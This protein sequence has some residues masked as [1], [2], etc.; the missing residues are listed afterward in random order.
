MKPTDHLYIQSF[1]HFTAEGIDFTHH[2]VEGTSAKASVS[3]A[4]APKPSP[5]S[6]SSLPDTL[7]KLLYGQPEAVAT[8]VPAVEMF[9][10][11]ISPKGR[12][13]GVFLLL[14]PTGTGKTRTAEALA[15][16]LHGNSKKLLKIDCG[17]YTMEHEIAKLI[18]APPGYLGH[19]DTVPLL[20]QRRLLDISTESCKLSILLFDEIEKA[21]PSFTRLL[22][23]ILDH[24]T[25]HL[26]DNQEVLFDNTLVL[27]T[28]NLGSR[29]MCDALA[30]AYGFGNLTTI[31]HPAPSDLKGRLTSIGLA[32]VSRKFT[33]EFV[34]RL[35]G[36]I[37]Y[38]PLD[39]A[40]LNLILDDQL[41]EVESR[42]LNRPGK[43]TLNYFPGVRA[44]LLKEGTSD[45][46][47]ARELKRLINRKLMQPLA[48]LLASND[49]DAVE[50]NVKLV[51]K[52][53]VV[54]R[55]K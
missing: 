22:L 14:G 26:G 29:A 43:V 53:L 20:T 31:E 47:G 3:P 46:Y 41:N 10:A 12:P 39:A 9:Q 28:S 49:T 50:I 44:F 34:N 38:L 33:P 32:A 25:L 27:M 55:C 21:A 35:D 51:E 42:L 23:G 5:A 36:V 40:A 1:A 15:Q 48:H 30:P 52:D 24:G 4:K 16:V 37:T 19:R 13:A 45:R 8:L 6:S 18:G 7:D 17:E 2:I 54:E 11:G